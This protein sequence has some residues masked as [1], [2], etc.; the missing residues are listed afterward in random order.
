M[1]HEDIIDDITTW[2][3]EIHSAG[4]EPEERIFFTSEYVEMALKAA[5][6]DHGAGKRPVESP[7]WKQMQ[8]AQ[9]VMEGHGHANLRLAVGGMHFND[10]VKS[11][12]AS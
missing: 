5:D 3:V 9:A 6:A 11:W 8:W 10:L 1:R 2:A 12:S 7:C 4:G